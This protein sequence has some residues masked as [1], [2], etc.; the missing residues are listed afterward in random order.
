VLDTKQKIL[1]T[2]ER[3]FGENGYSV[4]SLRQV[5]TEAEVNL[6]AVHYHFGS[7]EDLLDAVVLRKAGPVTQ[8]RLELLARV[9]ADAGDGPPNVERVLESF[10]LPTAEMGQ[11]N[12]T[13]VKLMGRMLSEGLMPRI[14]QKHFQE[15][16]MRFVA[17]LARA[18]PHLGREE[19]LWRVHFMIG[20]MAHTMTIEP[21]MPVALE[22]LAFPLRMEKL[23]RFLGAAFR[24]P[25]ESKEK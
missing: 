9:E 1:D 23:V 4:T 7:K 24:A 21:I 11:T 8:A 14:V 10:L 16:G 18:L 20:A 15:S 2:A 13:F 5:I 25:A 19:L 12:P 22:P 17:A 3:L 6:A